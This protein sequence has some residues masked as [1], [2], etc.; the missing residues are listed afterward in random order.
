MKNKKRKQHP[1]TKT[2]LA[3]LKP[4][5]MTQWEKGFCAGIDARVAAEKRMAEK[6]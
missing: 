4:L 6:R 3:V 2:L 1:F 5:P